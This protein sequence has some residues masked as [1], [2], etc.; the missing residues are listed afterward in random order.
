MV[1]FVLA[2]SPSEITEELQKKDYSNTYICEESL[3]HFERI[4]ATKEEKAE[5]LKDIL[6]LVD[7]IILVGNR[8]RD[9]KEAL[10]FAELIG[11]EVERRECV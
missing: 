11:L 6:Q 1:Y 8:K 10:D 3:A 5:A 2:V 4:G 7:G 9:M